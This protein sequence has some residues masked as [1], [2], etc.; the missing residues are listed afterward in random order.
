VDV[1][2]LRSGL[3]EDRFAKKISNLEKIKI[4]I[5]I[6][7]GAVLRH[8]LAYPSPQTDKSEATSG[9]DN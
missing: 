1:D 2:Y 7:Q 3:K 4:C 6:L 5:G 9:C 8:E